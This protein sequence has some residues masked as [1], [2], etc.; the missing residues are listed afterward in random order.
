[1]P[2]G[3]Y[4]VATYYIIAPCEASSNLARYDGVHYGYRT[5][6]A[7]MNAQLAEEAKQLQ[8]AGKA[9]ALEE[10]DNPL[11]RM[12]R[13]S[14]AEGFGTEVKRRIMLG[15]YALSAG[16]YDAYY[17]KALK[18]RRLIRQDY[19]E[20]FK[21]VDLIAGPVTSTPAFKI[22]EKSDDP[23]AM[24]LVDL[25]TVS[26]NL[27]GIGGI[28]FP[29]GFSKSGLPI[30]LQ[31]QAPPLE[32]ERLL[33]AAHMFQTPPTGTPANRRCDMSDAY[34]TII[35]LEVHVQLLTKSKLFC[36]CSTKFGAPPN[37]QTCPVCIGMPGTLP[38]MNRDA[39]E[40]GLKTAVA[41]NC[42]IAP[43]T[44]WDRKNY[45][46]PDLPKGYQ[47]SQYD[48]PFSPGRLSGNQRSQGT[49]RAKAHRHHPRAPGR[50]RRQEHARRSGR[51]SRQPHR[52]EPHR[53]AAV[54]D[55]QP[56]RHA[57]AAGGQGISH[58][59]EA[60]ADVP[61]RVRLQHAGGKPARRRQREPAHPDSPTVAWP[62][63][64]SWKSKT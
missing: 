41:L 6:E 12:Y 39:F 60:A 11:V 10:L 42:T 62:K 25:Y 51:Q 47:I 34:I 3:K 35:G 54:G 50:R 59:V 7:K 40:L 61:G 14:R 23:L 55:R 29:C 44:K 53:H 13:Q 16:Y 48:L 45:Y 4:G 20:A 63:R 52:S 64:R 28:S 36:G 37:T 8:A 9:A 57:L 1:M 33:R 38:V 56:A 49:L 17:L 43:F 26:A 32:E 46:Y 5:D 27:A 31:L 19:D 58:R 18:V 24:Y 30:G 15:T 22:G 2:H 21:E